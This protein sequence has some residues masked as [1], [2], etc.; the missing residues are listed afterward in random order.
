[1]EF[2]FKG[3]KFKLVDGQLK[4]VQCGCNEKV[5]VG[6]KES[7]CGFVEVQLLGEYTP[8]HFGNKIMQTSEGISLKYVSHEIQGNRLTVIQ[9]SERVEVITHFEGYD[10]T[11]AIRIYNE[12]KNIT[13]REIIIEDVSAFRFCGLAGPTIDTQNA[14]LYRFYQSH[15]AECQPRKFSLFDLGLFH[16]NDFN[17][18]SQKRVFSANI[19]SWSTKEELPQGIV[20]YKGNFTMFQIESNNS[21]LY[22]ISDDSMMLYLHLGGPTHMFGGWQKKLQPNETY[23]T[24]KVAI[25]FGNSLNNVLGEMTKY[26]RHIKGRCKSDEKLPSIFNSYMH[27]CWDLPTAE[28]IQKYATEVAKFGVK[29]FVIDCGWHDEVDE[30]Y[31]YVGN[32]NESK[33]RFPKGIRETTDFMRGLGLKAGL[34]IEPEIVGMNCQNMIDYYGDDCF[35]T[36]NGKKILVMGRYFLD[37]RKQKVIDYMTETIRRMVEDYGADY[38]KMDYN[39]DMRLGPDTECDS[40][41]EGLEQC[42]KAYLAWVDSLRER[43]PNVLFETCASGGLR[44]DYLTMQHYSIA[45]T[46]DADEYK[47]YPYIAGNLL[48]CILPEQGAVWSYPVDS[49]GVKR[50]GNYDSNNPDIHF[51]STSEWV[52]K[53]IDKEQV[54]MNMINSFLG[55]MHLA[56]HLELLDDEKKQLVKEGVS[57]YDSLTEDKL[58]SLPYLPLGFTDFSQ[59]RIASGYISKN[60]LYLAVWNLDNIGEFAI[61]LEKTWDI[62]SVEI[63]YP[64]KNDTK[65]AIENNV[66]KVVFEQK[67]CARFFIIKLR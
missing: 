9:R 24:V 14:Y 51:E 11:N 29:Y 64:K 4:L 36:R 30:V 55:R 26:R 57:F 8:T 2:E 5:A 3:L 22:E 43:F 45:S 42:G 38:I 27:L 28:V 39:E 35:I 41:G 1:M 12:V 48:A 54:T 33:K 40:A 16:A 47:R 46:S 20:E 21:W 62:E 44:M 49:Y 10:D 53:Y 25:C 6:N 67:Y 31:P 19:G 58:Q 32:W 56:S 61:P 63:G 13:D 7:K 60:T 15:N 59:Q 65:Y 37:Y 34:W 18:V 17:P 66:L 52:N 23:E 50:I